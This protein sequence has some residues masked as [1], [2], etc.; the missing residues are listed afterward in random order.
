VGVWGIT[1][2]RLGRRG[3]FLFRQLSDAA[4]KLARPLVD[5]DSRRILPLIDADV[6]VQFP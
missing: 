4:A 6:Q 3:S 1:S 5:V 2:P